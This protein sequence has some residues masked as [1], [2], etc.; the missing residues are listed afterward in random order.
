MK[1]RKPLTTTQFVGDFTSFSLNPKAAVFIE[2]LRIDALNGCKTSRK[3]LKK[4]ENALTTLEEL[5]CFHAGIKI[6]QLFT[7]EKLNEAYF[8]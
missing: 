6:S 7:K 8:G 4:I 3:E 1:T 5:A 2:D